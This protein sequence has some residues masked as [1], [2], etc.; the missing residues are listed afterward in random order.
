[1]NMN[2]KKPNTSSNRLLH[3][4]LCAAGLA[5]TLAA[6]A[7]PVK[8]NDL[9]VSGGEV[10]LHRLSPDN[11]TVVYLAEQ[12]TVG[13]KELYS[14]PANG[15][16]VTKL[17]APLVNGGDVLSDFR[18]TANNDFVIY[19]ADQ[20]TNDV[21]EIYSVPI[22]GGAVTKLN[23]PLP[24]G[25]GVFEYML[26][27]DGQWVVYVGEQDRNNVT[28]IYSVPVSGGTVTKLNPNLPNGRTV[29]NRRAISPDSSTVVYSADQITNDKF[30]LFSVPIT[31]GTA[32]RISGPMVAGGGI[33][34]FSI[35][36]SPD[37]S[38]VVYRAVQ[39]ALNTREVYSVPIGGGTVT[40]LNEPLVSGGNIFKHLITPD[41]TRVIFRGDQ[42]TDGL[43]ELFSVPLHGGPVTRIS[44][45]ALGEMFDYFISADNEHVVY[46]ISGDR[47]EIYTVPVLGG[48]APIQLNGP[49][50]A[51]DE[52]GEFGLSENGRQ[53]V[54]TTGPFN[55]D[56]DPTANTRGDLDAPRN[57]LFSVAVEGGVPIR[58][59]E[60]FAPGQGL[61]H[62]QIAPNSGHVFYKADRDVPGSDR[63]YGVSIGGGESLE[64]SG[65]MVAGGG[66][67][68]FSIGSDSTR[69]FYQADQDTA[70]VEELYTVSTDELLAS[71]RIFTNGFE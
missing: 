64:L 20:D 48:V 47:R 56:L 16:P 9:L 12:D 18:I 15:G 34:L 59:T 33:E 51:T 46:Q 58:L 21:Q 37:S 30:E 69:L 43:D 36:F 24:S 31:G 32:V 7:E 39:D 28:E 23:R 60:P 38:T 5:W 3:A 45:P 41:G 4:G 53:V 65:A 8:L 54:F 66:L 70:G 42:D 26:S 6:T 62:V 71:D 27:N 68:F 29:S 55:T 14:V 1:M 61:D 13:V 63:L 44:D 57:A 10:I 40:K 19:R 22:G 50:A 2:M 11:R 67:N 35:L 17:N 49:L 25:G 52:V